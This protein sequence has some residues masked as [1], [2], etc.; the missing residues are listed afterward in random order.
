[1][2][3]FH[4]RLHCHA[5]SRR[6]LLALPLAAF[7]AWLLV[8]GPASASARVYAIDPL[9]H[10][11]KVKPATLS[12]SDLEMTDLRWR[13]WGTRVARARGISRILTCSPSC[14]TGGAE[15]T[16][17]TVKLSR[18]RRHNGKRRYTCMSW[19]DDEK[20]T[21]LPDHGSLNP[22]NFRPCRPPGAGSTATASRSCRGLDMGF[23][24]AKVTARR[25]RCRRARFV[26]LEWKRKA[27][28]SDGAPPRNIRAL[29]FDCRFGSTD[30]L[31]HVRCTRGDKVARATWGG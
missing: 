17:T 20:V 10:K 19:Q 15:T 4:R 6:I 16:A 14:G 31:L 5:L 12:F 11:L 22:F 26:I 8:L 28:E 25:M 18:I 2:A 9:T 30:L 1:L 23:T 13:H 7:F 24:T 27:G 21:D 3:D 29:G